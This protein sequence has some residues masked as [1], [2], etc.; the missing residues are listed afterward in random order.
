MGRRQRRAALRNR[1]RWP[2]R[3]TSERKAARWRAVWQADSG[4][5]W[6][7][8]MECRRPGEP[9]DGRVLATVDH[10]EP[11]AD[12]GTNRLENLHVCCE[13]CNQAKG[14]MDLHEFL[15]LERSTLT[16]WR[17]TVA[18]WVRCHQMVLE[19]HHK[20]KE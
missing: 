13:V 5:C 2:R 7:C 12:G 1:L 15:A 10:V 3:S 20:G 19:D 18:G 14:D 4:R 8:R 9:W 16:G 17:R 6:Y 11:K